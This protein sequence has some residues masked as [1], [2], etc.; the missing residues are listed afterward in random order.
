MKQ[1][2]LLVTPYSTLSRQDI[3]NI[4]MTLD[5]EMTQ[6]CYSCYEETECGVCTHCVALAEMKRQYEETVK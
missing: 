5:P 6:S 1:N 4:G 2:I 3:F